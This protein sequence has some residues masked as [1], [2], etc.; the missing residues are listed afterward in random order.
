MVPSGKDGMEIAQLLEVLDLQGT[1]LNKL[2]DKISELGSLRQWHLKVS[3]YGTDNRRE[4]V[5]LPSELLSHE[6]ASLLELETPSIMMCTWEIRGGLRFL[7]EF[8]VSYF[9]GLRLCAVREC[10]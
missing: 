1:E 3:F 9:I 6:I 4:Y 10:A 2:A 5:K 8:G 7:S